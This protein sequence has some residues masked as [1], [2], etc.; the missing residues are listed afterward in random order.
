MFLLGMTEKSPLLKH[1][2]LLRLV[3]Q[4]SGDTK[5][6]ESVRATVERFGVWEYSISIINSHALYTCACVQK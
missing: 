1:S 4:N 6:K 5:F 2:M 3:V